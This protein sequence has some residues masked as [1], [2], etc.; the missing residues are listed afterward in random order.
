MK[1]IG[2]DARLWGV[3]HAGIGRYTEELVLHLLDLDKKNKYVLFVSKENIHE[4]PKPNNVEIVQVDIPHY[5]LKEQFVLPQIFSKEKLDLLHVPH[6]NVPLF[7]N[8]TFVVTIHD[9]LWHQFRGLQVTNLPAPLYLLKY[10][11][12]RAVL[13]HAIR[14]SV[15]IITPSYAVKN[16]LISTFKIEGGKVAVTYE[17]VSKK[18]GSKTKDKGVLKKYNIKDPYVLYVGSLYPHKNVENLARAVKLVENNKP[19]SLVV[20]SS[21]NVFWD[22]FKSF[23]KKENLNDVVDLVGYV[24]DEELG[25]LYK[26]TEAFVFPSFSEGFGLPG[27]EAMSLGVPVLASNIP[28]FKEIYGD[29][30]EYFDPRQPANIAE[31]IEKVVSSKKANSELVKQGLSRVKEFSWEEAAG[32][33][34]GI[35]NSILNY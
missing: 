13:N 18:I 21:R 27:L 1:K 30:V 34:L 5:G 25:S 15:K 12:Y 3:K 14:N 20:V 35:Y 7:Y 6:F 17:G 19:L 11:G 33:T 8:G 28:P 4:I 32:R 9:I 24:P 26:Q 29:A 31:I 16:D 2:I 10:L 22:R 23:L